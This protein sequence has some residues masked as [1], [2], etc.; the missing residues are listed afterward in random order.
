MIRIARSVATLHPPPARRAAGTAHDGPSKTGC[1]CRAEGPC[2]CSKAVPATGAWDLG[3]IPISQPNDAAEHEADRLAGEAMR[4]PGDDRGSPVALV[5]G[6]SGAPLPPSQRADFRS[7]FHHDFSRVRIHT[8]DRAS[9][10][11]RGLDAEAFTFDNDV[12]LDKAHLG[13]PTTAGLLAHELAHVVQSDRSPALARKVR[14][15]LVLVRPTHHPTFMANRAM[16]QMTRGQ[17]LSTWLRTLCPAADPSV[18]PMTG[19]VGLMHPEACTPT[20]PGQPRPANAPEASCRCLC[21]AVNSRQQIDVFIESRV[22]TSIPLN[23]GV[24][25][26]ARNLSDY[27]GA[28]TLAER[29]PNFD[30]PRPTV[31]TGGRLTEPPLPGAG[32]PSSRTRGTVTTPPW[33]MLSH[34]LC[35]HVLE[36]P[37]APESH[38]QTE[39][40]NRTAVD[41]EN[42]IRREHGLGVRRGAFL[43]PGF[44]SVWRLLPGDD[45]AGLEQRFGLRMTG[46]A[47]WARAGDAWRHRRLSRVGG[48]TE[49]IY[50][51]A[52][53]GTNVDSVAERLLQRARTVDGGEITVGNI[54]WDDVRSGD[55]WDSIARRWGV[56]PGAGMT[57][58]ERVERA[59]R[60]RLASPS[61]G[62]RVV[63]PPVNVRL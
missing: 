62:A 32:D 49:I 25:A 1:G 10:L 51:S 20:T 14:R 43:G 59:N 45:L 35:G 22:P 11:A 19:V 60:G 26:T 33:L 18:D 3:R 48:E 9:A 44:G 58:G 40:G 5:P 12:Y 29:D 21:E 27:G 8:D 7:R 17:L 4:E 39:E 34:E 46:R 23:P 57:A 55:T 13:R 36:N 30:P 53:R 28:V 42:Q 2:G 61:A 6:Q 37:N 54:A 63:I 50:D 41:T 24:P 31:V 52:W 16:A 15:Q 38:L 56:N 47:A